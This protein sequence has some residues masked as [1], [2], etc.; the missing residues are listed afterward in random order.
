VKPSE[1]GVL[2]S[3]SSAFH[4]GSLEARR[5]VQNGIVCSAA[6]IFHGGGVRGRSSSL[7]YMESRFGACLG[8]QAILT[9]LTIL[10]INNK[11]NMPRAAAG[12]V[13]SL[14]MVKQVSLERV[15][16]AREDGRRRGRRYDNLEIERTSCRL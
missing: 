8:T 11:I 5:A 14:G 4:V 12:E 6:A 10:T 15:P 3:C 2:G 9:I 16:A 1:L 7:F 13:R